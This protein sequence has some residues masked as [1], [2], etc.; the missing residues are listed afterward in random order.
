[1]T[2]AG[3]NQKQ[4]LTV[5]F[6]KDTIDIRKIFEIIHRRRWLILGV[7]SAIVS[8]AISMTMMAKPKYQG[9]MQVMVTAN[10]YQKQ[11]KES[12]EN[13]EKKQSDGQD[14]LIDYTSQQKLMTSSKL[15]NKLVDL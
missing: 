1:M 2:D 5:L 10:S 6:T 11:E 15:M 9:S 7:S 8:L 14:Y 4:I 13:I 3:I 12:G